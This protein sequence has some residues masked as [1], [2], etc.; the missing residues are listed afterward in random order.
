MSSTVEIVEDYYEI[1]NLEKTATSEEIKKAYRGLALQYHPDKNK[2]EGS[3]EKFVKINEA[4][5]TL[6]DEEKRRVYDLYGKEGGT[7]AEDPFA[8]FFHRGGGGGMGMGMGMGIPFGFM[9]PEVMFQQ[10][11][12]QHPRSSSPTNSMHSNHPSTSTRQKELID[13]S[14]PL[15]VFVNGGE[16]QYKFTKHFHVHEETGDLF[17][18]SKDYIVCKH[19]NGQGKK[20]HMLKMGMMI[21]QS[22]RTC[23]QCN[24]QGKSMSALFK[25]KS[26]VEVRQCQ[27]PKGCYPDSVI[28]AL[29]DE[30]TCIQLLLKRQSNDGFHDWEIRDKYLIWKPSM[31]VFDGLIMPFLICYHPNGK[32]YRFVLPEKRHCPMTVANKGMNND[33]MIVEINWIWD[34]KQHDPTSQHILNKII[35]LQQPPKQLVHET[36]TLREHSMSSDLPTEH[37]VRDI[38][39]E[40]FMNL[41]MHHTSDHMP[42]SSSSSPHVVQEAHLPQCQQS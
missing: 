22:I 33:D 26:K 9:P 42:Q 35:S 13:V 32:I 31:K 1:L 34:I 14:I 4:Y 20:I 27:L 25:Q 10:F 36:I 38:D 40:E 23:D 2:E 5:E 12:N 28:T 29:N 39:L 11:M 7:M 17:N 21:Q 3:N 19:C 37:N 8:S 18:P 41:S 16:V 24:G 6:S 15:D 30:T